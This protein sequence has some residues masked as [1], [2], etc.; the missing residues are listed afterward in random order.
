[1]RRSIDCCCYC[2]YD[3]S[4]G[5]FTVPL[6]VMGCTISPLISWLSLVN[7]GYFNIAVNDVIVCTAYGDGESGVDWA[8][9]TCSAVAD[10]VEGLGYS[11]FENWNC[12]TLFCYVR[13]VTIIWLEGWRH[14][15]CK[16][17]SSAGCRAHG[18]SLCF[19]SLYWLLND[20]FQSAAPL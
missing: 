7:G 6:V 18:K 8:E 19:C 16:F 20:P 2:S 14:Q 4:T 1:M 9:A 13:S 11:Y 5:V 15:N 10:V 3:S 12:S 17:K